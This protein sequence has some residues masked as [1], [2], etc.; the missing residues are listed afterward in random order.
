MHPREQVIRSMARTLIV[1][2]FAS[3][4]DE[5]GEKAKHYTARGGQDWMDTT[6]AMSPECQEAALIEAAV[7]YGGIKHAWSSEPWILVQQHAK[8][9][10]CGPNG[11]RIA[12]QLWGHY[13]VMTCLGHGVA[14]EDDHDV[15]QSPCDLKRYTLLSRHNF[16]VPHI[17]SL[18]WEWADEAAKAHQLRE[19]NI[20]L[21]IKVATGRIDG[22]VRTVGPQH[23][24]F[25]Q[26][27]PVRK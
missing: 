7:L 26:T 22:N 12:L 27:L 5:N 18:D 17:E 19:N 9:E 14:W 8:R 2:S 25:E 15:L 1:E 21:R 13:A 16:D 20:G 10:G 11:E 3:W 6:P 23:R 4:A 24:T